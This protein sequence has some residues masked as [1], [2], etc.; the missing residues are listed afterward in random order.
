MSR[1]AD[2]EFEYLMGEHLLY[3][4]DN[5]IDNILDDSEEDPRYSAVTANNLIICFVKVASE[6]GMEVPFSNAETYF[7]WTNRT[8]AEYRL[9]E[10]KRAKEQTYYIG[11]IF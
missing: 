7:G 3:Y 5:L 10:E 4:I 9:F 1:N 11:E 8:T 2:K 6:W